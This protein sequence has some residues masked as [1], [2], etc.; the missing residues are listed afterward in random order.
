MFNQNQMNDWPADSLVSNPRF[1]DSPPIVPQLSIPRDYVE[2]I[3][4]ISLCLANEVSGKA[5]KTNI[6]CY[7]YNMLSQNNFNNKDFV[8]LI[9]YTMSLFIVI[10]ETGRTNDVNAAI[11]ES[12]SKAYKFYASRVAYDNKNLHSYLNQEQ[13]EEIL[14]NL[15]ESEVELS[16]LNNILASANNRGQQNIGSH[17][18]NNNVR[19]PNSGMSFFN[20]NQSTSINTRSPGI[21]GSRFNFNTTAVNNP[22]SGSDRFAM[23]RN[24]PVFSDNRNTNTSFINSGEKN[25]F[26]KPQSDRGINM[27][28]DKSVSAQSNIL[29]GTDMAGGSLQYFG[30]TLSLDSV[31]NKP[32]S[33]G[34]LSKPS[35]DIIEKDNVSFLSSVSLD[36]LFLTMKLKHIEVLED[37]PATKIFR[38]YA[39]LTEPIINKTKISELISEVFGYKSD[40]KPLTDFTDIA[41][42]LKSLLLDANNVKRTDPNSDNAIFT[43]TIRTVCSINNKLTKLINEFLFECLPGEAAMDSFID[44][45]EDLEKLL[46]NSSP[47]VSLAWNSYKKV[48]I[49]S[50]SYKLTED[51]YDATIETIGIDSSKFD[52]SLFTKIVTITSINIDSIEFGCEVKDKSLVIE[53]DLTPNIWNIVDEIF[54][55]KDED[56]IYSVVDYIILSDGTN[57]QI[58]KDSKNLVYKIKKLS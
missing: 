32:T 44:D 29:Q 17:Y 26:I 23:N 56:K 28:Q 53:R 8:D 40:I 57:F 10:A 7:C 14:R 46:M 49:N 39:F 2:Y 47:N 50:I 42:N 6:R 36:D 15:N 48:L 19:Q 45:I 3:P 41:R 27:S 38:S 16:K 22:P 1:H 20:S 31:I 54:K 24:K 13:E 43:E 33:L 34:S 12:V 18:L 35:D 55:K 25:N 11:A 9:Q 30:I 58:F 4:I 5:D 37:N 52:I 21:G 51:I